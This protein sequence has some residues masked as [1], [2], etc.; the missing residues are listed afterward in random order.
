MVQRLGELNLIQYER[1][2]VILLKEDGRKL[3]EFLLRRHNMVE[4]FLSLL[5]I[6]EE[7]ILTE[8]EKMEHTISE[9]TVK[10][11]EEFI[12]FIKDNPDVIYR[13]QTYKIQINENT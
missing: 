11:F 8:T 13:F 2:G 4:S 1:Y 5:G 6:P 12:S 3:G 10:C 9:N 7:Q